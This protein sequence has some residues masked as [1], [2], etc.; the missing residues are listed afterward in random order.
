MGRGVYRLSVAKRSLVLLVL[1]LTFAAC[2]TSKQELHVSAAS[3][4]AGAF[5]EME[6]AFEA[7]EP[8]I[9]VV[10]NLGGSPTLGYQIREGAPIDVFASADE[11]VMSDVESEGLVVSPS[12]IFATN[13]LQIV[14]PKGNPGG[15][16]GITAFSDEQLLL[17]SCA[18]S[19]PCGRLA[20][21]VL[22]EAGVVA[23]YDTREANVKALLTKVLE[24]ELDAGLVYIT[25]TEPGVEVLA[26]DSSHSATYP[27]APIS[28]RS[29]SKE[30]V[31]F[32]LSGD[33]RQI[34]ADWG[35][36]AP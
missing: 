36:G 2:A 8:D 19:V 28:D 15:V 5:G 16:T 27:I 10:L 11:Q 13:R 30:F 32:V 29:V 12:T 18:S 24:G 25:D 7:L 6:E 3:S 1:A 4:L 26:V 20:D 35:F 9:D 31:A 34:L 21:S 33:G 22:A 14:M 23:R 17:G